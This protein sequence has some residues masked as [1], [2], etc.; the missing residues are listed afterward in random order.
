MS[1]RDDVKAHDATDESGLVHFLLV[2]DDDSHAEITMRTVRRNG[3][4]NSIDRVSDGVEAMTYLRGEGEYAGRRLPGV[5]LLDL[6]LPRKDGHEV[7]LE[8]KQDPKLRRIPVVVLTTSDAESDR[9]RA[10]DR[11]VNS[12]LVKPIDFESFR[13]M[14]RGLSMYWA[15]WNRPAP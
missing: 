15:V 11:Y 4:V 1:E 8:M 10:Y 12:Y 13:E 6:K 14:V 5:V 7:L 2:E 3:V 9:E